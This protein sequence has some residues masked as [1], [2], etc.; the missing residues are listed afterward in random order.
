VLRE[1]GLA[2]EAIDALLASG[3]AMTAEQAAGTVA[4]GAD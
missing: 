4:A 3:A 1:A 2:E